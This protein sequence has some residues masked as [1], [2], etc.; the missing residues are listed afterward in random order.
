MA[1]GYPFAIDANAAGYGNRN[2]RAVPVP[3]AGNMMAR[4]NVPT[5][6]YVM[7]DGRS[8]NDAIDAIN[9]SRMP[10][11]PNLSDGSY[12]FG[13]TYGGVQ[14]A[15]NSIT[16]GRRAAADSLA[17]LQASIAQSRVAQDQTDQQ[18]ELANR[19]QDLEELLGPGTLLEARRRNDLTE[20]NNQRRADILQQNADTRSVAEMLRQI[21]GT[22]RGT[23]GTDGTGGTAKQ[24]EQFDALDATGRQFSDEMSNI[25]PEMNEAGQ[26]LDS[27]KSQFEKLNETIQQMADT[28]ILSR[29]TKG[30]VV[31]PP[32]ATFIKRGQDPDSAIATYQAW[33]NNG[34]K[35]AEAQQRSDVIQSQLD[36]LFEDV[37]KSGFGFNPEK[38][39]FKHYGTGQEFGIRRLPPAA[40]VSESVAV[41]AAQPM[42]TA[43]PAVQWTTLPGGRR[44]REKPSN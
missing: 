1:T 36:R 17:R 15:G 23:R 18:I 26:L 14:A 21:N 10:A 6:G 8:I 40:F 20:Q 9:A 7:R 35:F 4:W 24:L 29:D 13:D 32:P 44:Y 38:A 11:G 31:L 25:L 39:A 2:F 12:V 3:G 19:K 34:R 33:Q 27:T 37:R 16:A 42:P 28:G 30:N 43:A 22:G 41:P 5:G